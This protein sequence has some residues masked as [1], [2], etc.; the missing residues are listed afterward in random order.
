MY[1]TKKPYKG[2]LR[3]LIRQTWHSPYVDIIHDD[4]YVQYR[5]K[6]NGIRVDHT[7]GL[8]TKGVF[9]WQR[10]TFKEA[11][12]DALAMNVNDLVTV[13][14]TAYRAH[15]HLMLPEDDHD[16]IVEI[17]GHLADICKAQKIAITGGETAIHSNLTGM[18]IGLHVTG[19]VTE[20]WHHPLLAQHGDRLVC[21]PSN[22][23]H[24]N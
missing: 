20:K 24:S 19:V 6:H 17:T 13:G 14:A 11:A 9:H 7:D 23:V 5:D 16:A 18:E 22:G 4:Y 12:Q 2:T 8:G 21:L 3:E 10:R 15:I 1:D